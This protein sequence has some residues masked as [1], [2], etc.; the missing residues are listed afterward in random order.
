MN[1]IL[2]AYSWIYP[3]NSKI[4]SILS[5]ILEQIWAPYV[6]ASL[7]AGVHPAGR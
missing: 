3:C 6:S 7:A 5:Y 4:S 2:P 1:A